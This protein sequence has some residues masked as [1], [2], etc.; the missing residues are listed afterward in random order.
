MKVK[1]GYA[2]GYFF[3]VI[4]I[5]ANSIIVFK[6][7]KKQIIKL[8]Y[9]IT[10]LKEKNNR[11]ET[12][13]NLA[14]NI[15]NFKFQGKYILY[16]PKK[17]CS[18][19]FEDVVLFLNKKSEIWNNLLVYFDD[20]EKIGLVEYFVDAYNLN[21]HYEFGGPLTKMDLHD[22]ILFRKRK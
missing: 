10:E 11:L 21:F 8:N 18:P 16:F 19:C 2:I 5:I 6:L 22:I 3:V 14:L 15:Q 13:M 1:L 9:R 7:Q 20:K 12:A 17:A 4:A